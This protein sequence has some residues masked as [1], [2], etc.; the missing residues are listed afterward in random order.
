MKA[1]AFD[2]QPKAKSSSG[3]P[4]TAP[5]SITQ[6]TSPCRPSSSRMRGTLAEMP[7]PRL[8]ALP[9]SSSCATRRAMTFWMLNSGTRKLSSGRKISPEMAG[10]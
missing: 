9:A 10:S 5:C 1:S 7:K 8:T 4:P 3:T 6:V 2:A